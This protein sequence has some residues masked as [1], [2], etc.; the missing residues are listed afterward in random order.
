MDSPRKGSSLQHKSLHNMLNFICLDVTQVPIFPDQTS[1]SFT[2]IFRFIL[3]LFNEFEI[4]YTKI[5]SRRVVTLF[6]ISANIPL[7]K[8]S[9]LLIHTNWCSIHFSNSTHLCHYSCFCS[10]HIHLSAP[11]TSHLHL[12]QWFSTLA[13]YT[14]VSPRKLLKHTKSWAPLPGLSLTLSQ[15]ISWHR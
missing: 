12:C 6:F 13:I 9:F 2:P 3:Q 8:F 4:L 5:S 11:R 10:P 1:Y 15:M 7:H 14:L